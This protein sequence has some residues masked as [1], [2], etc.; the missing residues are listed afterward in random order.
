MS[1]VYEV[2]PINYFNLSETEKRKGVSGKGEG[3]KA[4]GVGFTHSQGG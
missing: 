2:G 4:E 3:V 1:Y